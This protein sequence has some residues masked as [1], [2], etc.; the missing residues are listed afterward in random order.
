MTTLYRLFDK[1]GALLYIGISD[2]ALRRLAEHEAD[3]PWWPD[4]CSATFENYG[5]REDAEE[6]ETRFIR[7]ERPVYNVRDNPDPSQVRDGEERL[8]RRAI[9]EARKL[10][11]ETSYAD[12]AYTIP[13]PQC[14]ALDFEPCVT[15][16]GETKEQAHAIRT[17]VFKDAFCASCGSQISQTPRKCQVPARA[18]HPTSRT[19]AAPG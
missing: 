14:D 3:K 1:S 15:M 2:R 18:G 9:A 10:F 13:C 17:R 6:A 11:G 16:R 19:R 12:G 8:M 4:V 5:H 7:S